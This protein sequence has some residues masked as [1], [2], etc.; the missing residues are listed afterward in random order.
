MNKPNKS[1]ALN[2]IAEQG[3]S[4]T[5]DL[6]PQIRSRAASTLRP[7]SSK[8]GSVVG[9]LRAARRLVI[10]V[11][12]AVLLALIIGATS[13]LWNS[14]E[15]VNAQVLLDQA[16]AAADS[17]A[18]A[19]H[20]YHLQLT[21][22]G[23]GKDNAPRSTE[24]WFGGSD[25]QRS[26]DV[27]KDASGT[28]LLSTEV[29]FNGAHV[30]IATAEQ[31]QTQV[32]HTVGTTWNKPAEDPSRQH[33]LTDVLTQYSGDKSCMNAQL[34]GEASVAG[35][36]T[37]VIVATPKFLCWPKESIGQSG[38][39]PTED[40]QFAQMRVWVDKVSY[41]PLK[42]E[43]RNPSG[44]VLDRSEVTNVQYNIA[45]PD[46][47]F[48]YT[49][50]AGASVFDFTGGTGADVK[51]ALCGSSSHYKCDRSQSAQPPQKP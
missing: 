3:V 42:T 29:V 23:P 21:R 25:R 17:P 18:T 26:I 28:V 15:L 5:L 46:S 31:A 36:A 16:Q 27:V 12:A 22:Q 47:T 48:S 20:S 41:L 33:S 13:P 35:Q 1:E 24:I 44:V 4:D 51:K 8:S 50:P 38:W 49:P 19:V 45:I 9:K 43:V 6:W 2:R 34:Q 11:G 37:Y 32:V 30:W 14:A 40:N 10:S 39:R 7:Q